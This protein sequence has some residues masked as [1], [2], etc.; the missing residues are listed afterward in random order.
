[1]ATRRPP[2]A[3]PPARTV[4]QDIYDAMV[5]HQTYL[6]R[7]SSHLRNLINELLG[8]TEESIAAILLARLGKMVG[9]QRP[10]ELARLNKTL[11]IIDAVRGEAWGAATKAWMDESI[12]LAYQEPI[13]LQGILKTAI[14]VIIETTMPAARL[15][16]AIVTTKPFEGDVL[17]TWAER[18]KQDDLRRIHAAVQ[19]GMT[20]G[21]SMQVIT[22]RVIGT[23]TL[24]G[25]DGTTEMTRRQVQAVTRTSVMAIAN[26]AR[27]EY[28]KEN[29][30]ILVG[31]QYVATLDA[32][33]TALC[34]SLDGQLYEPGTGP[35][36]PMHFGCRSMRISAVDG[37]YLGDRPAKSS[38]EKQLLREYSEQAGI[39]RPKTRAALPKG[40]KGSYDEFKRKRVR[41]MTGQVPSK[42]SYQEWLTTQTKEFQ[43]NTLGITKAKLFREGKLPLTKFVDRNGTELT[44]SQLARTEKAAFKAAGLDPSEYL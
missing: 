35:Q 11:E 22:S 23:G 10:V 8:R 6:L 9:I 4:N 41:E 13:M 15:L 27:Q 30:D 24:L 25:T 26:A 12:A 44:L 7:Y 38:T 2:P 16:K 31:E 21:E 17:K 42:T 33:T 39:D 20:A 32:R 5:R 43:D 40:H 34:K 14:P 18:M 37:G 3:P 1:M 36:P 19:I 28:F 29:K